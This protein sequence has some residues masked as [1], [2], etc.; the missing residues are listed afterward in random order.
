MLLNEPVHVVGTLVREPAGLVLR[1]DGGGYW[2][3]EGVRRADGLIGQRVEVAGHRVGFNDIACDSVWRAGEP[4]PRSRKLGFELLLP[5]MVAL[6][7][8]AGV[9]GWLS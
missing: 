8:V 7:I 3:L 9:A 1:V 6:A 5:V 4:Q 2:Q